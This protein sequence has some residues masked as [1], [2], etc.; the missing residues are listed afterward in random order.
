MLSRP[1]Y[2]YM[3]SWLRYTDKTSP[4]NDLLWV[5]VYVPLYIHI[6]VRVRVLCI[7]IHTQKL[8]GRKFKF[9]TVL[10]GCRNG[11]LGW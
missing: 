6:Q 5:C 2:A 11:R 8:S 7:Y 3:E 4:E 1:K 9:I 10:P